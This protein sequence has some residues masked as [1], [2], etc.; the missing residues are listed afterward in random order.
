MAFIGG[1]E[2]GEV[3]DKGTEKRDFRYV[4]MVFSGFKLGTV[5]FGAML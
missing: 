2:E 1:E 4:D 3:E 5:T